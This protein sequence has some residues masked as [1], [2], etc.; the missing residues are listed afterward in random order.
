MAWKKMAAAHFL[1]GPSVSLAI[2]NQISEAEKGGGC[3]GGG[4]PFPEQTL[5][6]TIEEHVEV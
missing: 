5:Q 3:R 1:P 2:A 6:A 4:E